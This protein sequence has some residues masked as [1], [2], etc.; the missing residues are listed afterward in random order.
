M[1]WEEAVGW[2]ERE[3][4]RESVREHKSRGR[5]GTNAVLNIKMGEGE[6]LGMLSRVQAMQRLGLGLRPRLCCVITVS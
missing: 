4:E 6:S 2:S 5:M 1:V 3:R